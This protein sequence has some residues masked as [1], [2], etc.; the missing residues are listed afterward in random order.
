MRDSNPTECFGGTSRLVSGTTDSVVR[1]PDPPASDSSENS[2]ALKG[3]PMALLSTA[4]LLMLRPFLKPGTCY[5]CHCSAPMLPHMI[6]N[7]H[8][9]GFIVD[10]GKRTQKRI[11]HPANL[12][13]QPFRLE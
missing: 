12:V 7:F 8:K 1:P 4:F 5:A 11:A 13:V 2:W 6:P 9:A 3:K 10:L